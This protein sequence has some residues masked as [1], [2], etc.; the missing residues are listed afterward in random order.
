MYF[1][2]YNCSS[3]KEINLKYFET[4]NVTDMR[5]MFS[6]CSSLKYLDLSSFDISKSKDC[7]YMMDTG[8]STTIKANPDSIIYLYF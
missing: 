4:S 2:F 5:C 1:M 8:T 6:N 3:L 7:N